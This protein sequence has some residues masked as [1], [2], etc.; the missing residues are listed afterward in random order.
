MVY[1]CEHRFLGKEGEDKAHCIQ[2]SI[3]VEYTSIHYSLCHSDDM[4]DMRSGNMAK[5]SH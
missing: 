4:Q 2:T 3:Y 1:M 5:H